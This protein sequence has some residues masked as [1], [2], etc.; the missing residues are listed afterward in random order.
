MK[1]GSSRGRDWRPRPEFESS[2]GILRWSRRP[3]MHKL[4]R[5][6]RSRGPRHTR[7]RGGVSSLRFVGIDVAA[8]RH[9]VA[10][11]DETGAVLLRATPVTKDTSGYQQLLQLLGNAQD[12]LVAMEATGH[13][14]RNL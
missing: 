5:E 4:E 2:N 12:G 3:R 8:E 10:M 11:V 6:P 1:R 13:Y 14:W 7:L 9:V